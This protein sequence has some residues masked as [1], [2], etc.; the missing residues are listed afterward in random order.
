MNPHSFPHL[1][2]D[3]GAKNIGWRKDSLF[4]TCGWEKW[5]STCRKLKLHPCL[6][7]C[8]SIKSKWI[9]NHNIR[10]ETL[11]L[12]HER[13][14][15]TLETIC[16]G[17][18]FLGGTPAAQQLRERMDKWDFIKLKIFCTQKKWFLN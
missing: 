15:N 9:T 16:K 6:S 7:P 13:A 1:F 3:K 5:L 18:N 12:V 10:P 14:E 8:T 11:Q 4:N 17:K 2:F